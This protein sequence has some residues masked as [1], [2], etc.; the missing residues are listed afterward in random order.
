VRVCACGVWC[1]VLCVCVC[2]CVVCVCVCVGGGGGGVCEVNVQSAESKLQ[3]QLLKIVE[4]KKPVVFRKGN[5]S[6]P[7][8]IT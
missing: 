8:E 4:K 3:R 1:G 7:V 6:L 5:V 2:V